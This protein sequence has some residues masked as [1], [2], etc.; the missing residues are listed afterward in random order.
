MQ[1][2]SVRDANPARLVGRAK[3]RE[4]NPDESVQAPDQEFPTVRKGGAK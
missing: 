4:Q 1:I 3:L 2:A